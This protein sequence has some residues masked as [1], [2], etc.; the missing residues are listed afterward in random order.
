[1]IKD[2]NV[3]QRYRFGLRTADYLICGRCGVYIAAV[4]AERDR[5]YGIAILN[6]LDDSVRFTLPPKPAN[7]SAEDAAARRR[8]RCA[9]WTPT[10]IVTAN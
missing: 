6:A 7:Y 8:R 4:L 9:H 2:A 10:E 5:F 3:V 1:M